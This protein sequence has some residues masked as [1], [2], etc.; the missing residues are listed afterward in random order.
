VPPRIQTPSHASG[1]TLGKPAL[2]SLNESYAPD[3]KHYAANP[4]EMI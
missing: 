4:A 3:D 1:E 2:Q